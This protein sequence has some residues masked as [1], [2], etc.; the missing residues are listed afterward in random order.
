VLGRIIAKKKKE[1]DSAC[2][3]QRAWRGFSGRKLCRVIAHKKLEINSA[4]YIQN[5][6]RTRV[7]RQLVAN[8]RN[9]IA[10]EESALYVF[11]CWW[12]WWWCM[13]VVCFA[14]SA[15][16]Y[17]G[18]FDA[19]DVFD[20][21]GRY[22]KVLD[23]PKRIRYSFNHVTPLSLSPPPFPVFTPSLFQVHSILVACRVGV[24]GRASPVDRPSQ[25]IET[26]QG[27]RHDSKLLALLRGP[28]EGR[29]QTIGAGLFTRAKRVAV[30]ARTAIGAFGEFLFSVVQ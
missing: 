24:P 3:L 23:P 25:P 1:Y 27:C 22:L 19:F 10:E 26:L 29:P 2:I 30:Q 14:W 9:A 4:I 13:L 8:M 28:Q 17:F 15:V 7:S 20:G 11:V 6:W 16:K 21:T 18:V 12:W 5:M